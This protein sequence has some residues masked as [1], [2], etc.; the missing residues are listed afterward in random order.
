MSNP[1]APVGG[2]FVI[3]GSNPPSL[4]SEEK[5]AVNVGYMRDKC[6]LKNT[7]I[8]L[9]E[10]YKITGVMDPTDSDMVVP[11]SYCDNNS[12]KQTSPTGTG[13]WNFLGG[14]LGGAISG[15][16]TQLATQGIG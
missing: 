13:I 9:E 6:R 1:K 5:Q 16:L 3:K 10:E 8:N 2:S 7:D 11:K 14:L 15:T 4:I 12:G